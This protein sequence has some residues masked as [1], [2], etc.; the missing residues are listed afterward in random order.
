MGRKRK[1]S[2]KRRNNKRDSL[3][4]RT[5]S[6]YLGVLDGLLY[7]A[8]L[9]TK[10]V[11]YDGVGG[12]EVN[13]DMQKLVSRTLYEALRSARIIDVTPQLYRAAYSEA[14][15]YV[16]SQVLGYSK[17]ADKFRIPEETLAEITHS[18][19]EVVGQ[20]KEALVSGHNRAFGSDDSLRNAFGLAVLVQKEAKQVPFPEPL[21]FSRVYLGFQ[22]GIHLSMH[23]LM[24]R[25]LELSIDGPCVSIDSAELLGILLTENNTNADP[26]IPEASETF[27][28]W[29]RDG[30]NNLLSV[31]TTVP[32][33]MDATREEEVGT[34]GARADGWQTPH[35]L[36]PWIA[37]ILIDSINQCGSLVLNP[38][39][40]LRPVTQ[41]RGHEARWG[42]TKR[43]PPQ[44]YPVKIKN[45]LIVQRA[46][47][48]RRVGYRES[49]SYRF[50]VRG[51]E[52]MLVER[53]K[54]PLDPKRE[55]DLRSRGYRIFAGQVDSEIYLKLMKRGMP[56]KRQD[57]WLAV[58][59]TQVKPHVK[60]PEDAPHI[61][62]V[63][64]LP[65]DSSVTAPTHAK[66]G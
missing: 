54:L 15:K 38:V 7:S 13:T 4:H 59:T 55:R 8:S 17:S 33:W 60:G 50:D 27:R 57:E 49:P 42:L 25:R 63:R 65:G 26:P 44:W 56:P 12:T 66:G 64:V 34:W 23:E 43:V 22:E 35:T 11:T 3:H 32:L 61:R 58:L 14:A 28:L 6:N 18:L 62:S 20:Y 39:S 36:M 30:D 5:V 19:D 1:G 45:T 53:D 2:K 40:K 48:L 24:L 46:G 10:A 37:H 41:M 47:A 9:G 16:A 21:P 51:H 29:Y 31:I 52:R